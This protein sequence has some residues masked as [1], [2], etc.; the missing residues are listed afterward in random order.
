VKG[1]EG[2]DWGQISPFH[3]IVLRVV[4]VWDRKI[5]S[6]K[7]QLLTGSDGRGVRK[8]DQRLIEIGETLNGKCQRLDVISF[9]PKR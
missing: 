4:L 5:L 1:F 6:F 9:R 7:H 3:L 8:H 2:K